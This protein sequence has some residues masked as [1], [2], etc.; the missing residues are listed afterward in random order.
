MPG[1]WAQKS[2]DHYVNNISFSAECIVLTAVKGDFMKKAE[3]PLAYPTT[4]R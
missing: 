3:S 2:D 4:E 1:T